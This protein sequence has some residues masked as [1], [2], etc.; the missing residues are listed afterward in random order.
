MDKRTDGQKDKGE[1]PRTD[2]HSNG[3]MNGW[4][5]T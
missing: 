5:D 4:T 1:G 2:R 3:G